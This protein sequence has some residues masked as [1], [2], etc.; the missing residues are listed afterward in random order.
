MRRQVV[1]QSNYKPG[2]EMS[3]EQWEERR[4]YK[5]YP[6]DLTVSFTESGGNGSEEQQGTI[7]N[8]SRGGVFVYTSN[9]ATVGRDLELC[10][11]VIT[12]FGEKQVIK[13]QAKVVWI[14]KDSG[15]KGMGLSFTKIDRHSQYALLACAYRG[16][17]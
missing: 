15:D 1:R 17:A 3:Y 2:Q 8:V 14:G 6:S 16:E 10:I 7:R 12:P 9:P 4:K 13:A 11:N 5:R